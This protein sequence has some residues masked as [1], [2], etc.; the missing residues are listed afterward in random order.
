M[1][2]NSEPF[3]FF[4]GRKLNTICRMQLISAHFQILC[5]Q[6]LQTQKHAS[7]CFS[8][9]WLW[10]IILQKGVEMYVFKKINDTDCCT[11]CSHSTW[12]VLINWMHYTPWKTIVRKDSGVRGLDK[13]NRACLKDHGFLKQNSV[14]AQF[15]LYRHR[16][17]KK[18]WHV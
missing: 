10:T 18:L 9:M 6:D 7:A 16:K 14:N 12:R 17:F 2:S 13:W 1:V 11:C 4:F 5:W 8:E 15:S 3:F